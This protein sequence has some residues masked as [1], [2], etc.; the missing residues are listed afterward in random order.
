MTCHSGK[1]LE[2]TEA[3]LPKIVAPVTPSDLPLASGPEAT[4]PDCYFRLNHAHW[5]VTHASQHKYSKI[6]APFEP[7]PPPFAT[8]I[9]CPTVP[10]TSHAGA[11]TGNLGISRYPNLRSR[12]WPPCHVWMDALLS[13]S[14]WR[15]A[16]LGIVFRDR[17]I[18]PKRR[19]VWDGWG[20]TTCV[21]SGQASG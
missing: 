21:T 9:A 10:Q 4:L 2:R 14:A 16:H 7:P 8:H 18:A 12:A 15:T 17:S 6:L 3:L 5:R 19:Q 1:S 11:R 13:S 20:F